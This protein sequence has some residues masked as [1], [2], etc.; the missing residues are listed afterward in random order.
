MILRISKKTRAFE[1][2][3]AS[4]L[5]TT[6]YTEDA[7][8]DGGKERSPSLRP[9]PPPSGLGMDHRAIV[10]YVRSLALLG[11]DRQRGRRGRGGGGRGRRLIN[12]KDWSKRDR[13]AMIART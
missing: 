11:R 9:P 7:T 10:W 2:I 8:S 12:A 13:E 5:I 6:T 1:Q 4:D 3:L